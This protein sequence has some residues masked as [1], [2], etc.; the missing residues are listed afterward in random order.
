MTDDVNDVQVFY[1]GDSEH[2]V[3]ILDLPHASITLNIDNSEEG[4][5]DAGMLIA[6]FQE[7]LIKIMKELKAE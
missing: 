4:A 1:E 2:K 5:N 7:L 3:F 6:N